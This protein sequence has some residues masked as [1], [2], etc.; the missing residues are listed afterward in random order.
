MKVLE[1]TVNTETATDSEGKRDSIHTT[2]QKVLVFC[3]LRG[4][5]EKRRDEEARMRSRKVCIFFRFSFWFL[6]DGR[7]EVLV[8]V[9]SLYCT[10]LALSKGIRRHKEGMKV[11]ERGSG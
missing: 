8:L 9:W 3:L 6:E 1:N 4:Q 7:R 2:S 11:L 10:C 5:A